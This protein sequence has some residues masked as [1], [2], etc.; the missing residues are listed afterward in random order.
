MTATGTE[1][2][3]KIVAERTWLVEEIERLRAEN[4]TLSVRVSGLEAEITVLRRTL[5]RWR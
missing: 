1:L 2:L 5:D 4:A 3:A